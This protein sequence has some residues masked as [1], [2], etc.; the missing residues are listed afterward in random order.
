MALKPGYQQITGLAWSGHG[1]IRSV[2]ITADGGRHWHKAELSGPVLPQCLTRFRLEWAWDG[3][4]ALLQSPGRRQR[5]PSPAQPRGM[6]RRVRARPGLSLQR[7]SELAGRSR[8]QGPQRPCVGLVRVLFL[9]LSCGT[10]LAA[11][12]RPHL[13]QPRQFRPHRGLGHPARSRRQQPAAGP[14]QRPRRASHFRRALCH[15]PWPGR[16]GQTGGP[17]DRRRRLAD[18]APSNAHRRQLLALRH[19]IVRYIRAAMPIDQPRSL[20]ANE[21]YALCA[22]ILSR[23]QNRARQRGAGCKQ[24]GEG[25]NAQPQR[26]PRRLARTR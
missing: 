24:P 20:S 18:N 2:E 7:R 9:A 19:D 16:R 6:G 1:A 25:E 8:W 21:A 17:P 10:A 12:P 11:P 3:N 5:R 15:V 22:Y 23:G 26:L 13:G 14:W 4:P